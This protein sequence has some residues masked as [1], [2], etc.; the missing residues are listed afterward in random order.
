[1][2]IGHQER[3]HQ[4]GTFANVK[5]FEMVSIVAQR[6]KIEMEAAAKGQVPEGEPLR[7][8]MH[9]GPGIGKSL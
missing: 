7:W 9:G 3:A 1:M 6:V 5:Q 2:V 4:P 8:L